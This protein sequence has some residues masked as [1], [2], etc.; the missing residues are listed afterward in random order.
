MPS[1]P[2]SATLAAL[3]RV[4][5]GWLFFYAGLSH[6]LDPAWSAAAYLSKATSFPGVF[7][8]LASPDVLPITNTLNAWGL[9]L[10]GI[11]LFL[12]LFVRLGASAGAVLMFLYYLPI[13]DFPFA[14]KN[15]LLVDEHVVYILGLLLLARMDA[16]TTFGL[17]RRWRERRHGRHAAS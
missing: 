2:S 13:L 4:A 6:L 15:G 12:G 9:L 1:L 5:F 14:G 8:W 3:L 11:S 10:V 16:G 7:A 17:D